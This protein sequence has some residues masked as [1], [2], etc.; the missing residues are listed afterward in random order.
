MNLSLYERRR[1][2]VLALVTTCV[3]FIAITFGG[4]KSSSTS[5]PNTTNA[6]TTST[7]LSNNDAIGPLAEDAS[8]P[9]NLDGPLAQQPTGSADIA[10]PGPGEMK[11]VSARASYRTF[12]SYNSTICYSADAPLGSELTIVNLNNGKSIRCNNVFAILLP[13]SVD[14]V[15][16][17]PLFL[18]IANLVDAPL[19]VTVS[20]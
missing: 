17:T 20:W 5:A 3:L 18:Q 8:K 10:Y 9:V 12:P 14:I 19:P 4:G 1:V 11:R 2:V 15:L 7:P 6:P 13:A 16:H